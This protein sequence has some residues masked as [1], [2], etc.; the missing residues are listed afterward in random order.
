MKSKILQKIIEKNEL[1]NNQL[2]PV[3]K[4]QEISEDENI[5]LKEIYKIL[6]IQKYKKN[7][8]NIRIK[9]YDNSEMAEIRKKIKKYLKYNKTV[10]LQTIEKLKIKYRISEIDIKRIL[11]ISHQQFFKLKT[12][13]ISEIPNYLKIPITIK[14]KEIKQQYK[15]KSILTKEDVE[16]LIQ[17]GLDHMSLAKI[18]EVGIDQIKDLNRGK[19][20]KIK[21]NL[22]VNNIKN[23]IWYLVTDIKYL[24]EYGKRTYYKEELKNILKQ[25][26][27]PIKDFI[28]YIDNGKD[29]YKNSLK[30][31][32]EIT[33]GKKI[34]LSN[35][36]FEDNQEE[37]QLKVK[38]AVNSVCRAYGCAYLREELESAIY[39][40]IIVEGGKF[41][42]N[43]KYD[44]EK[45]IN[46]IIRNA[47]NYAI[48]TYFNT[49]KYLPLQIK[50]GD[51]I[52]SEEYNPKLIDNTYNPEKVII[53]K[54][55]TKIE[56]IHKIILR[57]IKIKVNE[58][59]ERPEEFLEILAYNLEIL[60]EDIKYYIKEIQKILLEN[61]LVRYDK[62]GRIIAMNG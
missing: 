50:Y 57:N 21:L 24:E 23:R 7:I 49:P 11:Y 53:Q 59:I 28:S 26:K 43:I 41:E 2:I 45:C 31:S 22:K 47:K 15:N 1:Y 20:K 8:K 61:G 39:E 32:N 18:F 33:L 14:Q 38:N 30:K 37:I 4:I 44:K 60:Y 17:K 34:Q 16:K 52:I 62:K 48:K 12:N 46:T 40:N 42:K 54:E 56:E 29:M 13:K 5:T 6:G 35:K 9:I 58:I 36:F 25:Y 19:T 3:E 27:I 51:K 10:N 55:K